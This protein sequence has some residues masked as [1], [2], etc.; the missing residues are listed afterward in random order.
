MILAC[1][2]A[3][4]SLLGTVKSASAASDQ[5]TSS[6][7]E[8]IVLVEQLSDQGEFESDGVVRTLT[9]HLCAAS[10]LEKQGEANKLFKHMKSL[11]KLL[12]HQKENKL[13]SDKAYDTLM[14]KTETLIK[15]AFMDQE[16]EF[17]LT[18]NPSF[19]E[20]D[21]DAPPWNFWNP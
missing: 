14:E 4:I 13:I 6:I 21:S 17:S 3:V 10:H 19:E 11:K 18:E 12:N 8:M 15:E 16:M 5:E 2:F 9:H 1:L 20:G 7:E